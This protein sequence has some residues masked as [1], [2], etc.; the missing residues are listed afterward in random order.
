[1]GK[2]QER[3]RRSDFSSESLPRLSFAI[4]I[5]MEGCSSRKEEVCPQL[6]DLIPK[7]REWLVSRDEARSHGSSEEKKLELRLGPPGGDWS[8]K[9]S[10]EKDESL[11]SLGCF[12]RLTSMAHNNN[13]NQTQKCSSSD[14]PVGPSLTSPWG[15]SGYQGK[16]Q[17]TQQQA[18]A[19]FLPFPSTPQ[20]LPV[21]AKDASQTCCTKVV[22]LQ[23][24]EKKAFS[25]APANT[26]VPNSSQKRYSSFSTLA[27][28][29]FPP[30]FH[31]FVQRIFTH[32][33]TLFGFVVHA[34]FALCTYFHILFSGSDIF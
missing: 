15:S 29:F 32:R 23:N 12:S 11:L 13:G 22:E 31:L 26:A 17:H 28:C 33:F 18:Q 5:E 25:P 10:R 4:I 34:Y 20:S 21:I 24:V 3:K 14:N 27:M 6:L 16:V 2:T 7:N 8:L 30:F 19:P 1:M 9:T